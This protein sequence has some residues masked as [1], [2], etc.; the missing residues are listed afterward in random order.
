MI[1]EYGVV[2]TLKSEQVA[3]VTCVKTSACKNCASAKLCSLGRDDGKRLVE[4]H[5]KL[6]AKEGDRV[7]IATTERA[8]YKSSFLVYILPLFFLIIGAVLGQWLGNNLLESVDPNISAF[9]LGILFLAGT[10]VGICYLNQYLPKEEYMP[11]VV[12]IL[13][14]EGEDISCAEHGGDLSHGY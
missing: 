12:E 5:N 14:E 6:G 11:T 7:K 3:V 13:P 8:F 2:V 1:E 10:F 4:A 9:V